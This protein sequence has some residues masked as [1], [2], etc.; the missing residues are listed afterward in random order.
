MLP[1]ADVLE[2][3]A[4]QVY[5]IYGDTLASDTSIVVN[6]VK[7]NGQ[8]VLIEGLA[9]N[10]N[11]AKDVSSAGDV[12]GDGYDDI[13]LGA[14]HSGPNGQAFVILVILRSGG[15]IDIAL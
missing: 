5:V 13:I 15:K 6:N 2:T 4:G 10:S 14:E 3:D 11:F 1:Y 9:A 7:D 12:D 8:G